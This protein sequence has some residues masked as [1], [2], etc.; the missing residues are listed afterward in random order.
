[1]EEPSA[2]YT[3]VELCSVAGRIDIPT[4]GGPDLLSRPYVTAIDMLFVRTV[5]FH[6]G[7]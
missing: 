5:I 3:A 1:M 7:F 4:T 2:F 6:L